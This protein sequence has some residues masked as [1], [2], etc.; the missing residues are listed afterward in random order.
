KEVSRRASSPAPAP[1]KVRSARYS[2]P[3]RGAKKK[4][5]MGYGRERGSLGY[6]RK[7]GSLGFGSSQGYGNP[8]FGFRNRNRR[9]GPVQGGPNRRQSQ[10]KGGPGGAKVPGERRPERQ[11]NVW[12]PGALRL[13]PAAAGAERKN[14]AGAKEG[15]GAAQTKNEGKFFFCFLQNFEKF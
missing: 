7:R 1:R 6:G 15:G 14:G 9:Q 4:V 8:V 13:E 11:K 3:P 12:D 5:Q 10:D 2:T